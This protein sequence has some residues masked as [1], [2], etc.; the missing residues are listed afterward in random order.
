MNRPVRGSEAEFGTVF[1]SGVDFTADALHTPRGLADLIRSK[2][3][4]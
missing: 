1:E 4:A 3:R 2:I